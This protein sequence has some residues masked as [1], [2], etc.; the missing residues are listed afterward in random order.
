LDH[1]L[2]R[3]AN[4]AYTK[5]PALPNPPSDAAALEKLL[6]ASGFD[7]VRRAD[8]LGLAEM[9]RALRDF[10][11]EVSNA[12]IA[13]VFFAGHGIEVN[14][15]NYLVPIDAVLERDL[16]V[17][18]EALPLERVNQML[19]PAKR[20]RLIILDACRDNPFVRSMKRS[21]ASRSIGRGL[22]KVEV[23]TS[24]TLI[25]YAAKAGSTAGDGSG[26]NSPYTHALINH[27]MTP[28][29]DVRLAL[30]RV[31]DEAAPRSLL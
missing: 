4:G 14:G 18:D 22:A 28:G 24:D 3:A 15:T 30:G 20:L 29:L 12:D 26:T 31:R 11:T 5:V 23:L 13:I 17:E 9:R 16:D 8:N 6:S 25:A 27:L 7:F 19:E 10:S 21:T 1:D 2:A